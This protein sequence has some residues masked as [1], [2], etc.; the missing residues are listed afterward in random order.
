MD[1][2]KKITGTVEAMGQ[3]E[4][5]LQQTQYAYLR[6]KD[7]AGNVRLIK[8]VVVPNTV[9]SYLSPGEAGEFYLAKYSRK[10]SML[11]AYKNDEKKVFNGEEIK[12]M[13]TRARIYGISM[14]TL[15]LPLSILIF[16]LPLT[17]PALFYSYLLTFKIPSRLNNRTF[18][19]Y[20][21]A[22]GWR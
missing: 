2:I 17:L 8:N 12:S 18:R 6:I 1:H 13:I 19:K 22:D 20:L 3:S 14:A 7:D 4:L 15:S 5:T 9:D 10:R 21:L 16:T 11:F